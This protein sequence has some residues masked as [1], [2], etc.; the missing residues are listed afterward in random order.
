VFHFQFSSWDAF[1]IK[2]SWY[3]C[4]ERVKN[5]DKSVSEINHNYSITLDDN[6]VVTTK[7]PD[8]WYRDVILP[9]LKNVYNNINWRTTQIKNWFDEYGVDYFKDLNIWH[10][11]EIRDLLI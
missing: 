5:P 8:E 2:Q 4:L 10:V 3:R 6:N 9:D 1:Q 7:A 11:K